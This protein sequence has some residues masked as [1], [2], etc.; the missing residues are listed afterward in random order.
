MVHSTSDNLANILA[1]YDRVITAFYR[2]TTV[3]GMPVDPTDLQ[4]SAHADNLADL[5]IRFAY[6]I[7]EEGLSD[8][9]ARGKTTKES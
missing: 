4:A 7:R 5:A 1:D 6:A 8:T 2:A 3:N 9:L